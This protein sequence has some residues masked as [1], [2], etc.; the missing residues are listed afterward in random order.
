[1]SEHFKY[2]DPLTTKKYK[3][4]F[5]L[6]TKNL[7][8]LW[9]LS[10]KEMMLLFHIWIKNKEKQ[11]YSFPANQLNKVSFLDEENKIIA[12]KISSHYN[13]KSLERLQ[14]LGLIKITG[15]RNNCNIKYPY[16]E[17]KNFRNIPLAGFYNWLLKAGKSSGFRTF[18]YLL[19]EFYR[20]RNYNSSD[21]YGVRELKISAAEIAQELNLSVS[22]TRRHLKKIVELELLEVEHREGKKSIYRIPKS[23]IKG[24]SNRKSENKNVEYYYDLLENKKCTKKQLKKS[25][26]RIMKDL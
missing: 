16:K 10:Q 11:E 22:A 17:N 3:Q 24:I 8:K 20:K 12:V 21:G 26:K 23:N 1:M 6:E 25:M 18:A 5:R 14:K 2:P 9:S 7:N 13:S 19:Y 15:K 4:Y